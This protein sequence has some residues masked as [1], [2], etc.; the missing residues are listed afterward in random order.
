[1]IYRK[2][3]LAV[4][5]AALLTGCGNDSDDAPVVEEIPDGGFPPS[6]DDYA[7]VADI[8]L[9]L[10]VGLEGQA[11]VDGI[12][13]QLNASLNGGIA[14]QN[15]GE[16]QNSAGQFH[17]DALW[18]FESNDWDNYNLRV[19]DVDG[20][21]V[22]ETTLGAQVQGK[23]SSGNPNLNGF[24]FTI[25]LPNGLVEEAALA[26]QFSLSKD[27]GYDTAEK[28]PDYIFLPGLT[29]GKPNVTKEATSPGTGFTYKYTT[30]RYGYLKSRF[31]DATDGQFYEE[32]MMDGDLGVRV[33]S[34]EWNLV[35]QDLSVNDFSG[36]F[37]NENGKL[38][39]TYN[40]GLVRPN[41][42]DVANRVMVDESH[43]YNLQ[44][45]VEVYRHY[46]SG[47]DEIEAVQE[48]TVRIKG[49]T[50]AWNDE[51]VELPAPID[52]EPEL[53][54][55]PNIVQL[56]LAVLSG[57]TG[58]DLL[59]G[60][61][62]QLN[63][64]L[65]SG[66]PP[67]Q[68]FEVS[69]KWG[70]TGEEQG[71]SHSNLEVAQVQGQYVLQTTI[72]ATNVGQPSSS[73]P[74][75]NGFSF[76]VTYP[77]GMVREATLAYS[78]KLST[79]I[80]Y[81][82]P[83]KSPDYLYM[84]GLT[85]G[86]PTVANK[87]TT[88]G[89]GFTYKFTTDRYSKIGT[90]FTDAT[91]NLFYNTTLQQGGEDI[92]VASNSW[93]LVQQ[94]L[95]T[96]DFAGS[97]ANSNGE[98]DILY[99]TEP[100]LPKTG[101]V[102]NR[103][104]V[105]PVH[106][107][108]LSALFEVYRHYKHSADA[109]GDLKEQVIQIKNVYFA[110]TDESL[111]MPPPPEEDLPDLGG[112]DNVVSL[113]LSDLAGLTGD[114]LM[115]G[116]EDQL[117]SQRPDDMPGDQL[118]TVTPK[119]GDGEQGWD[120]SNLEVVN[121][122]G[123]YVLE[124]VI[125]P[126]TY[127]MPTNDNPVLNGFSFLLELPNGSVQEATLAYYYQL[128][129]P[130]GYGG[131]PQTPDYLFL[132]GFTS[133]D[134]LI[135]NSATGAGK[136]F[137]YKFNTDRYN[138]FST[139]FGDA[140]DGAFYNTTLQ[141]DGVDLRLTAN[142]WNL[143][144]QKLKVNDFLG[145]MVNPNGRMEMLYNTES[146]VSSV[147]EVSDRVQV[148]VQHDY[149]LSA[150]ME[151]YRHYKHGSDSESDLL[152]QIVKIKGVT[153]AWNDT[154]VGEPETP[155]HCSD[156]SFGESRSL[157]LSD[158]VG[159]DSQTILDSIAEQLGGLSAGDLGFDDGRANMSVSFDG[160]DYQLDVTYGAGLSGSS[161]V[162]NGVGFAVPF[163]TQGDVLRGACVAFDMSIEKDI[164]SGGNNDYIYLPSIQI[165][166]DVGPYSDHRY[167]TN[168]YKRFAAKFA[169]P[170]HS[171]LSWLDYSGNAYVNNGTW[172]SMK[173]LLQFDDTGLGNINF[174]MNGSTYFQVNAGVLG[175][176][177]YEDVEHQ[178]ADPANVD[179]TT[180]TMNFDTHRHVAGGTDVQKVSYRNIAIGW[181]NS[182]N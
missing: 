82:D 152:E 67:G 177:P 72:P 46:V 171:D 98:L 50:L 37:A 156:E 92:R 146:L 144:Q 34:N 10:L 62:D 28:S 131:A 174:K 54:E 143:I 128:S 4:S 52:D 134:P 36:F 87:P 139:R 133:G 135:T 117:N 75:E 24:S 100:T 38:D 25:T 61:E 103:V 113:E 80:G 97:N 94:K 19:V 161:D 66:T 175:G 99:R 41:G 32:Q 29:S 163:P 9:S 20:T 1:M 33:K 13:D 164:S 168:K 23:P 60:I 121:D 78:Y 109:D 142:K 30:D 126:A 70:V 149:N 110:W 63:N 130:L 138:K 115:T 89:A 119:W 11:L 160:V 151:V 74:I 180:F 150:L 73:N 118:F 114:A 107:Y 173:Q 21:Y 69:S 18:G 76:T 167:S 68:Y 147:G 17:V 65:P 43:S 7:N 166:N 165:G 155:N 48:Q 154:E 2:Y 84:P 111:V 104:Q 88:G 158:L 64:A 162:G 90:R 132:P 71:W 16:S 145:S 102:V 12:E 47:A 42:V 125:E 108:D 170:P 56:N 39:T 172:I 124:T 136:G 8:D 81:G 159:A 55:Y 35:Q 77:D 179:A 129:A 14:A 85:S 182:T 57:V 93:N 22:L 105:E 58:P 106:Q 181:N 122:N 178:I 148:D 95:A 101:D 169:N 51:I 86:D 112:F 157:D 26:Y 127:S 6:V 116:I 176:L 153:I 59:Q 5:I 83:S 49:L 53:G 3:L 15:S 123:S 31:G 40:S 120:Q 141:V 91:D 45:M 137:T 27:L 44:A 140:T 79:A 96:N